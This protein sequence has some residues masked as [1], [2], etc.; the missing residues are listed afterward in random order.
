LDGK[1]LLILLMRYSERVFL[2]EFQRLLVV[3]VV[4][5]SYTYGIHFCEFMYPWCIFLY[6]RRTC[7]HGVYVPFGER[8]LR[9][10]PL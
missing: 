8:A 3:V 10:A 4:V 7:T 2:E 5:V 1:L 6:S 9:P